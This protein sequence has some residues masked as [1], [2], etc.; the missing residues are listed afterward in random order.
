M[1]E[2]TDGLAVV[3]TSD[4]DA[5]LR[6]INEDLSSYYLLGFYSTQ[7]QDGKFHRLTVRVKRSGVQ[8]RAR[9]GYLAV[10]APTSP[11]AGSGATG[12]PR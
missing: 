12:A 10:S 5:S 9:R 2:S 11:S 4:M 3:T 7:K 1:A 6:R 8:V